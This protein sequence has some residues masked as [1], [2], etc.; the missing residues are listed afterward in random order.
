MSNNI[1]SEYCFTDLADSSV[2][3][4]IFCRESYCGCLY[5]FFSPLSESDLRQTEVWRAR[6]DVKYRPPAG[7]RTVYIKKYLAERWPQALV[8]QSFCCCSPDAP[9]VFSANACGYCSSLTGHQDGCPGPLEERLEPDVAAMR[10]AW[11]YGFRMGR[12][13]RWNGFIARVHHNSVPVRLGYAR[14]KNDLEREG[15]LSSC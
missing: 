10:R 7:R 6:A 11:Y 5:L 8:L 4:V 14:G 9:D 3:A 13:G 12:E 15:P 2:A 1:L